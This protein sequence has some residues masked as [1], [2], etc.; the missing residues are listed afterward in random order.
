MATT[1]AEIKEEKVVAMTKEEEQL[2]VDVKEEVV[3]KEEKQNGKEEEVVKEEKEEEVKME[4]EPSTGVKF[5]VKVSDG[6]QLDAMGVRKK[7]VTLLNVTVYGFGIYGDNDKLKE[8]LKS[9]FETAP[10][11][12]TKELYETV[13][14]S[15]VGL[16]VR[17]VIVFPGL[18]MNMVRKNFDEVIGGVLKKLNG[19]PEDFEVAKRLM[20]E[21]TDGIKLSSGSVIEITRLPGY[22]LQTKVKDEVISTVESE[23]L[24]RAYFHLYLGEDPFDKNAKEKFGESLLSLF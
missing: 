14:D 21:A 23:L 2:K 11:K 10:E 19:A 7:R 12:P 4:V 1:E 5:P 13:I 6:K 20:G 24:C 22:T 17:L 9:K 3:T 18:T 16:M 8:L 15:D